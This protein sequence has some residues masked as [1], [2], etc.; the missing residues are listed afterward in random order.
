MRNNHMT[1]RVA[2][3]LLLAA[4]LLAG[5]SRAKSLQVVST[6]AST[7]V[8]QPIKKIRFAPLVE[9]PAREYDADGTL[10]ICA[11][12]I[13]FAA[14]A[15]WWVPISYSSIWFAEAD[16]GL[17]IGIDTLYV[18]SSDGRWTFQVGRKHDATAIANKIRKQAAS[19]SKWTSQPLARYERV[20]WD[21]FGSDATG[22]LAVHAEGIQFVAGPSLSVSIPYPTMWSVDSNEG[23]WRQDT[24]YVKAAARMFRFN[25]PKQTD[26]TALAGDIRQ[27][28]GL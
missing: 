17:F 16:E 19:G 21:S 11:E 14:R 26:V 6:A 9:Y 5:C 13:Q 3:P 22:Q 7:F 2:V 10:Q 20:R 4:S 23:Y 25:L 12:G 18:Y 1:L 27:R 24:L 28:A 15:G 8:E